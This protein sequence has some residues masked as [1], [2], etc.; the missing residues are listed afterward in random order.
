MAISFKI[1]EKDT[2]DKQYDNNV[3][4]YSSPLA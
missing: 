4:Y 1:K 3:Q 2:T